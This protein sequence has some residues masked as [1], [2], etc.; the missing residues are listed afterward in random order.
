MTLRIKNIIIIILLLPILSSSQEIISELIS[1][2]Y[3]NKSKNILTK[4]SQLV[5]PFFDDFSYPSTNVDYNLWEESAVFVNRNYPINPV[6]IGVATFDGLNKKGLAYDLDPFNSPNNADTL[7]SCSIDLSNI[8]TAFLMFFFQDQG[9]GDNPQYEDSLYLQFKDVNGNWNTVWSTRADTI[10]EFKKE[11]ILII[12]FSFLHVNFQFRF[13]NVATLSG[14]FD[15]WH[16]DY[17]K[18]DELSN[19]NDTVELSDITFV[20]DAPSFLKRYNEMPWTHFKYNEQQE[21]SDTLDV[22]IRN[23]DMPNNVDYRFNLYKNGIKI[24]SFPHPPGIGWRNYSIADYSL[25]G[26]WSHTPTI[27]F[28][29]QLGYDLFD[30]DPNDSATFLIEHILKPSGLQDNNPNNDTLYRIQK[31]HSHFAYDD[32]TA[33]SA[34]GINVSNSK[35]AYQFKLNRPDTIRAIQMYFPQMLNSVSDIAFNLTIWNDNNGIPGNIVYSQVEYPIHTENGMYHNYLINEPF[36]MSSGTFYVGWEQTTNDLLNIGLDRNNYSNNYMFYNTGSGWTNSQFS[37]S[38][39]IR[40][41]VSMNNILL[42]QQND[43]QIDK[44]NF[45]IYPNPS[46]GIIKISNKNNFDLLIK[47]YN[48]QG[49]LINTFIS[50]QDEVYVNASHLTSGLYFVNIIYNGIKSTQK[51]ILK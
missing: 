51:I 33:E 38:W 46:D 45:T 18:L 31:F 25:I 3:V 44:I 1:N 2:P 13:I 10:E 42:S 27:N 4:K 47:I 21:L 20:Y 32:G 40:P 7:T 9:I 23:N 17:V 49:I 37:G 8:N 36:K 19:P 39:M 43:I 5:L 24:D 48:T 16:L 15:H 28:T 26:N 41:I 34:Y 50:D 29:Q 30:T 14:N 6:S 22:L 11:I 35:L 12:D